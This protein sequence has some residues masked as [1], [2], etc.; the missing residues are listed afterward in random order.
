MVVV[1]DGL[2]EVIR[3]YPYPGSA[4]VNYRIRWGDAAGVPCERDYRGNFLAGQMHALR[5]EYI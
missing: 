2:V 3:V 1:I 5:D 4:N